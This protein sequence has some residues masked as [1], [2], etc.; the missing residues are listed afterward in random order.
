MLSE[1][2]V[3]QPADAITRQAEKCSNGAYCCQRVVA[4]AAKRC[5]V[6][7]E[8]APPV[9]VQVTIGHIEVR[10]APANA[11]APQRRAPRPGVSLDDYLQRRNRGGR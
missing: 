8:T 4:Q 2:L 1:T 10:T 5:A 9:E 3:N 7:S 6:D 11:P